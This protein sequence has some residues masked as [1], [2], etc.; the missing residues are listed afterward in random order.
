VYQSGCNAAWFSEGPQVARKSHHISPVSLPGEKAIGQSFDTFAGQGLIEFRKY[1]LDLCARSST[2][3]GCGV[4]C[5]WSDFGHRLRDILTEIES[6]RV[7]G[8]RVC[9]IHIIG[10]S[11]IMRYAR[12]RAS[13]TS[14]ISYTK[15]R[16]LI[17]RS[18]ADGAVSSRA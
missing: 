18:C 5:A 2:G 12:R 15:W 13:G 1:I 10:G 16:L 11:G 14:S 4:N 6:W 7:L 9:G 3:H 17:S 8:V